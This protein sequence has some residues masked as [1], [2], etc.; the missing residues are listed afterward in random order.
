V[1]DGESG[2]REAGDRGWQDKANWRSRLAWLASACLHIEFW[3]D[4]AT[5]PALCDVR[6][7]AAQADRHLLST[8][9]PMALT[10]CRNGRTAVSTRAQV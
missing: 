5:K 8:L 9:K 2:E 4:T 3:L 7:P 6:L 10:M 1:F